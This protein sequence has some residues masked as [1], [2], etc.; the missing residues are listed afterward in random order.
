MFIGAG[1]QAEYGRAEV[2]LA[3]ETPA[4]PETGYGIAKLC[5]GQMTRERARQLGLSHLWVR[6]AS[7]YGPCDN[8]GSL[9][10]ST[11]KA[12]ESGLVPQL[13]L[14]EQDWDY[15]YSGDAAKALRLLG[16]SGYDGKVY[17]LGSG[18]SRP[19]REYVSEIRDAVSPGAAIGIGTLPYAERQVMSLRVN[20]GRLLA[21]VGWKAETS[22]KA[23]IASILEK[24]G[25]S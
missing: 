10:M 20:V 6:L 13:T 11:I 21:D 19:L 23:G 3:P 24:R 25:A 4:L 16:E 14:G 1:S 15:L 9:V 5:A 22:F 17:V 18:R 12:L 2:E 8:E 7:V